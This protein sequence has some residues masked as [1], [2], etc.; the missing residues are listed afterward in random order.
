M[1]R[2]SC[3]LTTL[4]LLVSTT[5]FASADSEPK[6]FKRAFVMAGGGL[7]W[8]RYMGVDGA[9]REEGL[10]PDLYIGICGGSFSAAYSALESK[11]WIEDTFMI[12]NATKLRYKT[13]IPFL[14]LFL[15]VGTAIKEGRLIKFADEAI[16]EGVEIG[17]ARSELRVPFSSLKVPT[18]IIATKL[19]YNPY[20]IPQET[21]RERSVGASKNASKVRFRRKNIRLNTQKLY[22]IVF[23]TDKETAR[24]LPDNMKSLASQLYPN[25][26]FVSSIEVQTDVLVSDAIRASIAD[27]VLMEPAYMN[28]EYYVTGSPEHQP[29]S[30]LKQFSE[31]V[32]ESQRGMMSRKVNDGF[33]AV[34]GF[35]LNDMKSRASVV[36]ASILVDLE[37]NPVWKEYSLTP[38]I[39]KGVI[40]ESVIPDNYADFKAQVEG[41]VQFGFDQ[42]QKKIQSVNKEP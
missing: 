41:Q 19:L 23:F 24:R 25:A 1:K 9:L 20:K 28:G 7:D 4:C 8:P 18:I 2:I 12:S 30:L 32:V 14:D 6:P 22:Q 26:P 11:S 31:S 36:G 39:K 33:K 16:L 15:N 10:S 42:T 13:L 40:F 37:K 5:A 17:L 27:P 29:M 21:V 38:V 3:L 35:S 34:F